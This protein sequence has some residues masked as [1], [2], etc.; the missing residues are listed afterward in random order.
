MPVF[1][2]HWR[3]HFIMHSLLLSSSEYFDLWVCETA[4]SVGENVISTRL[5]STLCQLRLQR[6]FIG[7]RQATRTSQAATKTQQICLRK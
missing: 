3:L 5:F 1:F 2:G 4:C 6:A 7:W